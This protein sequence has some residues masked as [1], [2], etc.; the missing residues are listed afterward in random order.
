MTK[1]GAQFLAH[2][3]YVGEGTP[4]VSA[5]L[6]GQYKLVN[7][8]ISL[9]LQMAERWKRRTDA[10]AEAN[11][12]MYG[13]PTLAVAISVGQICKGT[14]PLL[15]C[16]NIKPDFNWWEKILIRRAFKFRRADL[17]NEDDGNDIFTKLAA[18][19]TSAIK[20][21]MPY[22]F[23]TIYK[24][25]RDI[26]KTMISVSETSDNDGTPFNLADVSVED[27]MPRSYAHQWTEHYYPIFATA[28]DALDKNPSYFR[29]VCGFANHL[30]SHIIWNTRSYVSLSNII[31]MQ[32][33]LDYRLDKWWKTARDK[34]ADVSAPNELNA[35]DANIHKNALENLIGG[36]ETLLEYSL[37]SKADRID[38]WQEYKALFL[39]FEAHLVEGIV[40][41][42]RAVI[43]ENKVAVDIWVKH[44]LRW[45]KNSRTIRFDD[46][47]LHQL[48][49]SQHI[50]CDTALLDLD[51]QDA[52][53][54][55]IAHGDSSF[56]EGEI[57][58]KM[59]F[60]TIKL[61]MWRDG[62]MVLAGF[63]LKWARQNTDEKADNLSELTLYRLIK[64][65]N[66]YYSPDYG[67]SDPNFD[68]DHS[69]IFYSAEYFYLSFLRINKGNSITTETY[70]RRLTKIAD[71]I[72]DLVRPPQISGR[73]HSL[74]GNNLESIRVLML[75]LA[76]AHRPVTWS[77]HGLEQLVRNDSNVAENLQSI[78]EQCIEQLDEAKHKKIQDILNVPRD[79]ADK[80]E[81]Y[82][83]F[84]ETVT[85]LRD[86]ISNPRA[87]GNA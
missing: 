16:I 26:H 55:F 27:F 34:R 50:I 84:K 51:W 33:T 83:N 5:K 20:H 78:L 72:E 21:D 39:G 14:F 59:L 86:T 11:D 38:D 52:K 18:Q 35:Y 65:N 44:L 66:P 7:I 46:L 25:L 32:A 56:T 8:N 40:N 2:P 29:D 28:T 30:C 79:T 85:A 31:S 41:T 68:P 13:N 49:A 54:K 48:T 24:R 1:N 76:L 69:Q 67:S 80:S 63:L 74:R 58:P 61:N 17:N 73:V 60:E 70:I 47:Y 62:C 4:A 19:A 3:L 15:Q 6:N 75:H 23:E 87:D 53:D 71:R 10:V 82:E 81:I 22:E 45:P 37:S 57:T 43:S 42:A 77:P 64:S 36:W 9:L 12:F